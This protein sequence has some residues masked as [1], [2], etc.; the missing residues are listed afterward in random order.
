MKQRSN[1]N[2]TATDG[3]DDVLCRSC[4]IMLAARSMSKHRLGVF[5]RKNKRIRALLKKP[6]LTFEEIGERLDVS[7]QRVHLMAKAMNIDGVARRQVCITNHTEARTIEMLSSERWLSAIS[8]ACSREGLTLTTTLH[9]HKNYVYKKRVEI[10][11]RACWLRDAAT[12][13]AYI[14]IE[15]PRRLKDDVEFVLYLLSDERWIIVPRERLPKAATLFAME[16]NSRYPGSHAIRHDWRDY[17][18]RWEPL[19]ALNSTKGKL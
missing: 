12:V 10:N 15:R 11:D 17:V 9:I 7:R 16:P 3:R 13:G 18:E 6:C 14:K 5:H 19:R 2:R 4:G 8:A 1:K